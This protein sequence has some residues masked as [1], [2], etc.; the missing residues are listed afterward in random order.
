MRKQIDALHEAA[1]Q[2]D[3]ERAEGF[4][5]SAIDQLEQVGLDQLRRD[6]G[7]VVAD[8]AAKIFISHGH[9]EDV[10][11]RVEDYVRALGLEPV[12]VKRG[13]SEGEGLDDLV[14]RRM[15]EC[16]AQI[17]LATADDAVDGLRQPRPNVIH[18]TGL[19]QRIFEKRIVY[20]KEDCANFPSNVAPKV[21]ESF[22]R[23]NLE[24]AFE[25]IAKELRA[26]GLL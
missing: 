7:Y 4:L 18:E 12:V 5:Q 9:A 19:G 25:K 23:D 17:I 20:L 8:G 2:K 21:W 14:E 24:T 13:A 1:F 3:L 10:L 26:F 15:E 22:Q 6:S 16:D 11:R